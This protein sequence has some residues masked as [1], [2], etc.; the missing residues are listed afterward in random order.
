[1]QLANKCIDENSIE[2]LCDWFK[3]SIS[4]NSKEKKLV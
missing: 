1:M 2:T 3:L 4:M